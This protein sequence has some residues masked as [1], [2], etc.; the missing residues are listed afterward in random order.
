MP[1]IKLPWSSPYTL[2]NLLCTYLQISCGSPPSITLI[3]FGHLFDICAWNKHSHHMCPL[4]IPSNNT[5]RPHTPLILPS[6]A[7]KLGS[8]TTSKLFGYGLPISAFIFLLFLGVPPC[9]DHWVCTIVSHP[10]PPPHLE[11]KFPS[12]KGSGCVF[13]SSA[14]IAAESKVYF[15]LK[16]V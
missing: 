9:V 5:I 16:L 7:R 3:L 10:P 11:P 8:R 6:W 4:H 13:S 15:P 14:I 2:P 12:L 1:M